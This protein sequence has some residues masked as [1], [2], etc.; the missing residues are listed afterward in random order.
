MLPTDRN[1][2]D[3]F[4]S[5]GDRLHQGEQEDPEPPGRGWTGLRPGGRHPRPGVGLPHG[6]SLRRRQSD[7]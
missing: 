4:G 5:S 1:V 3:R 2:P 6:R 7:Q